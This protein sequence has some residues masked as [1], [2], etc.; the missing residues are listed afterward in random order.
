MNIIIQSSA[1]LPT[2]AK[3]A[4][5]VELLVAKLA[6]R[7]QQRGHTVTVACLEGSTVDTPRLEVPAVG[8]TQAREAHMTSMIAEASVEA[9]PDVIFDHS[10]T[11]ISQRVMDVP[12]VTMSHGMAPVSP[13]ARNVVF[14]SEHHGRLHGLKKPVALH[15]GIDVDEVP[16][17][18]SRDSN[19]L[20]WAGRYLPYKQPH[21]AARVAQA[22]EV[23]LLM[24]GPDSDPRYSA[25]S[26][27][28]I[29][30]GPT[31]TYWS[32]LGE[33]EHQ[34]MLKLLGDSRALL[35]TS[36][37]Q[38]PAG[39][40]MLE[41]QAAGTPVLAFDHGANR[42]F[43]QPGVTSYLAKNEA[44][45]VQS[46]KERFWESIKAEDCR[47]YV[48]QHRSIEAMTVHAEA[49]LELAA[50]GERW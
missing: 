2:P 12:A 27:T 48:E 50:R 10:L 49:L 47:A 13:W 17:V 40:V 44:E 16:F 29:I 20:A 34:A 46:I 18:A 38:E 31:N 45:M 3:G 15:N 35:F 4:G 14:T 5:A 24:A 6:E 1:F 42:E 23:T 37:E 30:K 36:D 28:P 19:H 21:V 26:L 8:T 22:A 33:L 32:G 9:W 25:E 41:A 39:I 43:T 11:Q 7:L